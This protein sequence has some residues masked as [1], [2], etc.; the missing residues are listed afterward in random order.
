MPLVV[1]VNAGDLVT[2]QG[3]AKYITVSSSTDTATHQYI[4][5]YAAL[6]VKCC[7][8]REHYPP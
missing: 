8:H 4:A 6:S 3:H 7:I 1:L 2:M 5:S